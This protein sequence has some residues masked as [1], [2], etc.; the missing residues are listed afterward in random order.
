MRV[1]ISLLLLLGLIQ[2]VQAR[3]ESFPQPGSAEGNGAMVAPGAKPAKSLHT[4]DGDRLLA[5]DRQPCPPHGV[6]PLRPVRRDTGRRTRDSRQTY[7]SLQWKRIASRCLLLPTGC[8]GDV[9][10]ETNGGGTVDERKFARFSGSLPQTRENHS[11]CHRSIASERRCWVEKIPSGRRCG[12]GPSDSPV[13]IDVPPRARDILVRARGDGGATIESAR[14]SSRGPYWVGLP[15]SSALL[16]DNRSFSV[17]INPDCNVY[18]NPSDFMGSAPACE[19]YP[20]YIPTTDSV[21]LDGRRWS[22]ER[23]F[24][25][26]LVLIDIGQRRRQWRCI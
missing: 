7:R 11:S 24:D 5:R 16:F 21:T 19:Y 15:A 18:Y 17:T 8:I 22:V 26:T 3:E 12:Q 1:F 6:R 10:H 9:S 13:A 14:Q 25:T 2:A 23:R 20:A 4:G